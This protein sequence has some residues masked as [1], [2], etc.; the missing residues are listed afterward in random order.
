MP[1]KKKQQTS[2]EVPGEIS[3]IVLNPGARPLVTIGTDSV[4]WGQDVG[5]TALFLDS[6]KDTGALVRI[7]PP[8]D[9]HPDDVGAVAQ[10]LLGHGVAAVKVM[11]WER[12]A[13]QVVLT[14][15]DQRTRHGARQVVTA[16]VN[17]LA[18]TDRAALLELCERTMSEVGL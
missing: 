14:T 3:G 4:V 5:K 18:S 6:L 13:G 17:E 9:A 8:A 11:P 15:V 1:R 12:P 7:L 16:M 2:E 10:H